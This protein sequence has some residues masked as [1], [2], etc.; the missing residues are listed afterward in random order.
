MKKP[1]IVCM[2]AFLLGLMGL[3]SKFLPKAIRWCV[4]SEQKQAGNLV[5]EV[6][7]MLMTFTEILTSFGSGSESHSH[8]DS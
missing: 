2:V 8:S 7:G 5:S 6:G 3:N 1:T 4:F